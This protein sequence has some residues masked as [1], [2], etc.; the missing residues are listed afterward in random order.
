MAWRSRRVRIALP[1]ILMVMILMRL[2]W[3]QLRTY[4][5][6][7]E[8]R[9][10]VSL[11]LLESSDS[12]SYDRSLP[13]PTEDSAGTAAR[14]WTLSPGYVGLGYLGCFADWLDDR[15]FVRINQWLLVLTVF[16]C[17]LLARF[18]TSS[19]TLALI[20]GAMLMSRGRM[21]ADIS[22]V[23]I[24]FVAMVVVTAWMCAQAHFVR[25]GA[26]ASLAFAVFLALF[27]AAVDR[28][29]LVLAMSTP[30]ALGFGFLGR[31]KLARPV[32][33]RLRGTRR[34]LEELASTPKARRVDES[35]TSVGRFVVSVRWLL[36]MEFAPQEPVDVRMGGVRGALFRTLNVP[37]LL[38]VYAR[39]RWLRLSAG[40][41][42]AGVSAA[43]LV[44]LTYVLETDGDP[45]APLWQA[46]QATPGF[47]AE[48]LPTWHLYLAQRFDLHLTASLLVVFVCAMQSPAAG[49]AGF[50]ETSWL[51]L[52]SGLALLV[53]ALFMDGLDLAMVS[54][55]RGPGP[56]V[57]GLQFPLGLRDVALWFEPT[58]L[59]LGAAGIYNLM[60][61]FDTRIAQKT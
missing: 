36:G 40:W 52:T 24:D 59:T 31:R 20:V 16:L 33:R 29:L 58:I 42:M 45:T 27:G 26:V 34:R 3:M 53:W 19:W 8:L 11:A 61:V 6:V 46:F 38:W 50:L 51:V 41:A 49:L 21:L 7:P 28:S 56:G 15:E 25:T 35:T 13:R 47:V 30:M 5:V 12:C 10:L 57:F 60:K 4:P 22:R 23:S 44:L 48:I 9:A 54:Q 55:A 17:A 39:R 37:F 18:V 43:A 2:V 32:L 1:L 14:A